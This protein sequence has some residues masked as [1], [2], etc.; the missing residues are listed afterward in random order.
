MSDPTEF[1]GAEPPDSEGVV[2]AFLR[3][4]L[5]D[6]EGGREAG[7]ADYQALWP[8]FESV[9]ERAYAEILVAPVEALP[10]ETKDGFRFGRYRIDRELGRGGQGV[11]YA[12]TDTTLGREVA[13]KVL[14]FGG[15]KSATSLLRFRREAAIASRLRHPGICPV[16]DLGIEHGLPYLTMP[17]LS[18]HTLGA[19]L[20]GRRHASSP[21][22]AAP[23]LELPT[24]AEQ[25]VEIATLFEG[26]A[27]A[28]SSAH[29]VGVVHRDLKPHNVFITDRGTPILLD[30]GL[31]LEERD[32]ESGLTRSGDVV[33]TPAYLPPERLLP[34]PGPPDERGDVYALGVMCYEVLM[35]RRPFV[36]ATRG[37]L[38]RAILSERLVSPRKLRPEIPRG[39]AEIVVACLARDPSRRYQ[40]AS[41]VAQD[42]RGWSE[43]RPPSLR[44]P[45]ALIRPLGWIAR[46]PVRA[47]SVVLV[48]VLSVTSG[49]L[50]SEHFER[51]AGLEPVLARAQV[52]ASELQM[53]RG[54]RQL[55]DGASAEAVRLLR[56]ASQA[57]PDHLAL[58]AALAVAECV[59]NRTT[60][61]AP[62]FSQV[63]RFEGLL[64]AIEAFNGNAVV[65]AAPVR[66]P[67]PIPRALSATG[68]HLRGQLLLLTDVGS[69]KR[70]AKEAMRWFEQAILRTETPRPFF[71]EEY[72]RAAALAGE[73]S[74]FRRAAE[75]FLARQDRTEAGA[76]RIA[77]GYALLG[78]LAQAEALLSEVRK[79]EPTLATL[80]FC[81][82]RVAQISNDLR[83]AVNAYR[84]VLRTQL[85]HAQ[86]RRHLIEC[87]IAQGELSGALDEAEEGA[88][89]LATADS[90]LDLARTRDL[91]G[92]TVAAEGRLIQA[93]ELA[94]GHPVVLGRLAR[95]RVKQG[96]LS[97]AEASFQEALSANPDIEDVRVH[98]ADFLVDR[99]EFSAAFTQI[100]AG[101]S[102][103]PCSADAWEM[104][105]DLL[106]Q[107]D[108]PEAAV[109]AYRQA[110]H[111]APEVGRIACK[112]GMA[113]CSIGGGEEALREFEAGVPKLTQ[114]DGTDFDGPGWIEHAKLLMEEAKASRALP[115]LDPE[116]KPEQTFGATHFSYADQHVIAAESWRRALT[117]AD[118]HRV[119]THRAVLFRA[120]RST[121]LALAGRSR[122]RLGEGL[123]EAWYALAADHLEAWLAATRA[124]GER[125]DRGQ[126]QLALELQFL[127]LDTDLDAI[128]ETAALVL[129]PEAL[130]TRLSRLWAAAREL[131]EEFR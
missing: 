67:A 13:L 112:L 41:A 64:P 78:D 61:T 117:V 53:V 126:S 130:R 115:P 81:T 30:F 95:L 62:R 87:L 31:A 107:I 79:R 84:R 21:E 29:L 116:A 80:D 66:N 128:R 38:Y 12:A 47:A 36:G 56:E 7:L 23:T 10:P 4:V 45:A 113:L 20:A 73:T 125:F 103:N 18:G 77:I 121:A 52:D 118:H 17:L 49:I 43:G 75:C 46:E 111:C 2:N 97:E 101:L 39:L 119:I 26:I 127:R 51:R 8:G 91:R 71:L 9:I 96:K 40:T 44:R 99:G 102:S 55:G 1:L 24:T 86:A 94:P 6:R 89:R 48:L 15:R 120:A 54:L 60:Q 72:C 83:S 65:R 114:S 34:D 57:A 42:L 108:R 33:G 82:A 3:R 88:R 28:L 14:C 25:F 110:Q 50:I 106:V 93:L 105:A 109:L 27:L 11:V 22:G 124:E 90:L 131:E 5:L 74:R 85:D 35:G 129:C 76:A 70:S 122:D 123:R 58:S 32:S 98:Y 16:L 19:R 92:D 59:A 104:K 100:T 37:A 69:Q 68:C 63:A